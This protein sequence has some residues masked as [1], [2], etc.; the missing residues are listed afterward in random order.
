MTNN[1]PV[2]D[3]KIGRV[4]ASIWAN[5]TKQGTRYSVT[6]G[7]LFKPEDGPWKTSPS[8]DRDDL[9]AAAKALDSAHSWV[10]AQPAQSQTGQEADESDPLGE[11][12][13]P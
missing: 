12:M 4:K 2:H 6:I 11:Y 8:L 1:K 13:A 10:I 5:Q 9:L 7:R 3:V